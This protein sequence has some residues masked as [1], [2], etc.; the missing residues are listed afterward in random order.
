MVNKR[1]VSKT[2][3][4][5]GEQNPASWVSKY[6]SITFNQIGREYPF[7]GMNEA[8]LVV[9]QMW[10]DATEY[11]EPD[12][13]PVVGEL[14]WI[15][16][17]LDNFSS[18]AEVIASDSL[19][20]ICSGGATLHYLVCDREGNAATIEFIEGRMIAHTGEELPARVLTNSTYAE[21]LGYL[22]Q[23]VGFGGG[24]PMPDSR[25]SEDRFVRAAAAVKNYNSEVPSDVAI[26]DAIIEPVD[27]AFQTLE[28]VAQG[29][30][31]RWSIVYDIPEGRIHFRTL[32]GPDIKTVRL[33]DFDFGCESPVKVLDI[34]S[35]AAGSVSADFVDYTTA[36]N[37]KLVEA[38]FEQYTEAGLFGQM[39]GEETIDRFANYPETLP[40]AHPEDQ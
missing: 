22:K 28:S 3:V 29:D 23:H 7:G 14:Q 34:H 32:V 18:V 17:Q 39:P 37:R 24:T 15:Q 4:V 26:E 21:C 30:A 10:L 36:A 19:V 5:P 35:E 16:Y 27:Y 13:R 40:C 2:A 6:G 12:S 33:D 25:A 1:G 38:T 8:G 9:E 11:P 20:R 31:T